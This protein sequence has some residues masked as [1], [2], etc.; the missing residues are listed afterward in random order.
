MTTS[1]SSGGASTHTPSRSITASSSGIS[2]AAS[3][4]TR[5]H[6]TNTTAPPRCASNRRAIGTATAASAGGA[7]PVSRWPRSAARIGPHAVAK[8]SPTRWTP[9]VLRV[10]YW[11]LGGGTPSHQDRMPPL[12]Q[13]AHTQ[14]GFH[15]HRCRSETLD[16]GVGA[17]CRGR[18]DS[19]LGLSPR[20]PL[21]PTREI[22]RHL[23]SR[24]FDS[25]LERPWT[26]WNIHL[27]IW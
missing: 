5:Q 4:G 15:M 27:G 22:S 1:R 2:R 12:L 13:S 7:A 23:M 3:S 16:A 9:M 14:P 10:R 26:F 21:Q 19:L 24:F 17:F 11:R 25:I 6:F 8:A 20:L 18:V